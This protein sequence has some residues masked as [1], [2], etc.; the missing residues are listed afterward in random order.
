M[1]HFDRYLPLD[2]TPY[3]DPGDDRSGPPLS[4]G[5]VLMM[6]GTLA[7]E[8]CDAEML[9]ALDQVDSDAWYLGQTLESVLNRFEEADPSLPEEIGKTIYYALQ[10][11]FRSFG[12]QTPQ[13]VI[14]TLPNIWQ[15]VTRGNSG[16][17]RVLESGPGHARIEAAQPYNCNF[18][19]G[20][21]QGAVEAFNAR[22]LK[23]EHAQCQR[24]GAESCV[25]SLTWEE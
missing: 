2:L 5:F 24:H 9:A 18:E 12:I 6:I 20:A 7:S 8:H 14:Q 19:F 25:F 22:K 3:P 21:L 23:A 17:W 10:A 4:Q 13:D 16:Y 15:Q 11:T 1:E